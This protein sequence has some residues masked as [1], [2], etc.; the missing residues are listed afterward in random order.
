M[1]ADCFA[2][3]VLVVEGNHEERTQLAD[4]LKK[5]GLAPIEA[6]DGASGLRLFREEKPDLV[7]L[8]ETLPVM[9]GLQV[10]KRIKAG[11]VSRRTPVILVTARD[12]DAEKTAGGHSA[13]ADF[14][15]S[16]P[17]NIAHLLSVIERSLTGGPE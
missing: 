4:I 6:A 2:K 14:Y 17:Y 9:D 10:L 3:K 12:Y 5:A 8:E 13:P 11:P 16:K 1:R 15:L 7:I